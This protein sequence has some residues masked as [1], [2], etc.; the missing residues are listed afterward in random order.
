MS[1]FVEVGPWIVPDSQYNPDFGHAK[2]SFVFDLGSGVSTNYAAMNISPSRMDKVFL[3]HLHGDHVNDLAHLYH[4]GPSMDRKSPQYVWGPGPSDIM[5]PTWGSNPPRK[6]NDGTR[7]FCASLR[8]A[9]RWATESFSFQTTNRTGWTDPMLAG[10]C[11]TGAGPSP[12]ILP[13]TP[14]PWSPLNWI[15]QSTGRSQETTSPITIRRR[16]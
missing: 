1:V 3:T 2:D 6:Y 4:M 10:Q 12:M 14:T 8:S 7:A 11:L 15:G 5:C 9:L 16:A 13:T